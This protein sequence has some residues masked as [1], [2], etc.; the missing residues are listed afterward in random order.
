MDEQ[1]Q[2]QDPLPEAPA[3][4]RRVA[5]AIDTLAALVVFALFLTPVIAVQSHR[6]S[7]ASLLEASAW[8]YTAV[9][10]ALAVVWVAGRRHRR[11][12]VTVGM[13]IMNLFPLRTGKTVRLV[14]SEHAPASENDMRGRPAVTVAVVLILAGVVF[15]IFEL[16]AFT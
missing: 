3:W 1:A 16:L 15:F 5:R 6:E 8:I 14:H 10:V 7:A 12:Y 2:A 9:F 11:P 4:R 13:S